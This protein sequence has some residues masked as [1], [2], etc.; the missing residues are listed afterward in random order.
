MYQYPIINHREYR[1][2]KNKKKQEIVLPFV[3]PRLHLHL[4]P[5]GSSRALDSH[6]THYPTFFN[7]SKQ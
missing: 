3:H 5:Q 6:T 2:Q 7:L 4:W 1:W